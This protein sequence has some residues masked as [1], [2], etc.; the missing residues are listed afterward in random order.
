MRKYWRLFSALVLSLSLAAGLA[1]CSDDDG[2]SLGKY[3]ESI[4][5]VNKV[6]DNTYDFT[7]DNGKKLW[8]AAPAG[9]NL[10][11]KYGRAIINYTILSDKIDGYDHYIRLNG[12]YD[13]LTK[14]VIYI[15]EDDEIKQDSIGYDPI[16]VHAIWEGGGFLNIYFGFNAGGYESHMVNLV[17]AKEDFGANDEIPELAFRHNVNGDKENHAA[18]A[19][20]S[21]DLKPY[22]VA[23]K[24]K[25]TLKISW[26]D[27]DGEVKSKII[28][29]K[30]DN[31]DAPLAN[32]I[33]PQAEDTNLNIY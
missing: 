24:D 8:V 30:F 1:S 5:T 15:A 22:I 12:F 21:F 14:P 20:A 13:V 7:L 29:Y 4:V 17:T 2:Y 11:P 10:K 25:A 18:N 23:G 6:G 9:L 16:K 33:T 26:K 3:W 27:F 32:E 19:Y 31:E 28:E